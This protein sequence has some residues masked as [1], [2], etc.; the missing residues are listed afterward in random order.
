MRIGIV[1]DLTLVRRALAHCVEQGGHRVAWTAAEGQQAV[2]LAQSDPADL[3]LMDLIMPV[4]DGVQATREIMKKSPC[5]ILIVTISVGDNI[6][7]VYE[8]MGFGALD[9][10]NTPS[11]TDPD[12]IAALLAKIQTIARLAQPAAPSRKAPASPKRTAPPDD[13]VPLILIGSSTGGPHALATILAKL[14]A[15]LPAAV[16]IVQHI[17]ASFAA[18]LVEWLNTTSQLPV[19]M[20]RAGECPHRQHVYF[21]GGEKHLVLG[22][23]GRFGY[24]EEP[25]EC[26]YRPSVD[27]LFHS[28]AKHWPTPGQAALLTGMGSDGAAGLLALR[29][30]GWTTYAQDEESCIVYGMPR[31]AVALDAAMSVLPLDRFSPALTRNL[32]ETP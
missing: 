18:G 7:F 21:A 2:D 11:L 14:P 27:A 23:G 19:E 9:A 1:N 6:H 8:A 22:R 26:P 29:D 3:I 24:T 32:L 10:V 17:D 4:K 13:D 15:D 20:A 30:H 5:P 12:S 16:C 28:A 31:A 25:A